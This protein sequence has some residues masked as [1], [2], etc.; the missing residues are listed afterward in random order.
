MFQL[1]QMFFA[2]TV[3]T[4]ATS[5][6]GVVGCT[7][8]PLKDT[9]WRNPFET[10]DTS[11]KKA[12]GLT[13]NE[14][15]NQ[16]RELGGKAAD[17]SATE[18]EKAALEL[19]ERYES[20][21]DPLLR[22]E[23]IFALGSFPDPYATHGLR[24]AMSDSDPFVRVEACRAWGRRASK[25]A[26]QML[27]SAIQMDQS[28]DVRQV[29]I[30]GIKRFEHPDAVRTLGAVLN[31]RDPALQLLAM[32]SLKGASG[33]DL[34]NDVRKWDE[35]IA[36]NYPPSASDAIGISAGESTIA[37]TSNSDTWR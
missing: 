15:A 11:Y 20:E 7:N 2:L 31:E 14:V 8:G 13:P 35:F 10:V 37:E 30:Q 23:M 3:V 4:L 25:E 18:Q 26:L 36:A 32:Q 19:T 9:T 27:A 28:V 34:G 17:M 1:S 6:C 16:I 12:Y 33:K 21:N 5:L 29:A 24:V 22:R